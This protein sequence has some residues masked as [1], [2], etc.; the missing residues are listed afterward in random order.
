M[1]LT[2][3]VKQNIRELYNDNKRKGK[4]RGANGKARSRAQMIAI[5]FNAART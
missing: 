1:P 3:N 2:N 5:A 4:A